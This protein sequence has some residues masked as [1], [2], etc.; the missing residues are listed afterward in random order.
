VAKSHYAG[1]WISGSDAVIDGSFVHDTLS[2]ASDRTG[3]FGMLATYDPTTY[4]RSA[5]EIL[6]SRVERNRDLGIG[7]AGSDATIEGTR[8]KDTFPEERTNQYGNGVLIHSSVDTGEPAILALRSCVIEGS[9]EGGLA[10]GSSDAVVEATIVRDTLPQEEDNDFGY[11]IFVGQFFQRAPSAT[12]RGCVVERNHT[13]GVALFGGKLDV[14]W[15]SIVDSQPKLVDAAYG[16]GLLVVA[17]PYSGATIALS[18]AGIVDSRIATSHRAGIA[19]FGARVA[20]ARTAFECNAIH[21]N[22]ESFPGFPF[23]FRDDGD[24]H[25]GCEAEGGT[26]RVLSSN[27]TAPPPLPHE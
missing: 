3:G 25:C 27:L 4:R 8:V 2:Q 5:V 1:I 7:I 24:N 13:A 26:C 19:N 18:E 12:I 6:G 17:G 22:G 23:E 15:T 16:D 20:V 21:L 9:H 10:I 11:G 14:A